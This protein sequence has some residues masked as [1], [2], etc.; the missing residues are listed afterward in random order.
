RRRKRRHYPYIHGGANSI[1]TASL[2]RARRETWISMASP[3]VAAACNNARPIRFAAVAFKKMLLVSSSP[4][5]STSEMRSALLLFIVSLLWVW[6][7]S[8]GAPV[9][10]RDSASEVLRVAEA[11][12]PKPPAVVGFGDERG[13]AVAE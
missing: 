4:S 1:F 8:C 11:P 9:G 2:P 10:R 5:W 6:V 12:P 7:K 13:G 3:L